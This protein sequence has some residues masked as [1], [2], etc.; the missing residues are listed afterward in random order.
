MA[1]KNHIFPLFLKGDPQVI[2][3]GNAA[4]VDWNGKTSLIHVDTANTAITSL[5]LG[6]EDEDERDIKEGTLVT[7]RNT[8][9]V[10]VDVD[11]SADFIGDTGEDVYRVATDEDITFMFL[12][13]NT[14]GTEAGWTLL[15]TGASV[16]GS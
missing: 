15:S 5:T 13:Y 4:T 8:S 9:A 10:N 16:S 2:A 11:T 6:N 7:V 12:G 1:L 14:D 3:T